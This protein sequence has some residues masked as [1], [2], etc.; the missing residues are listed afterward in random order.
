MN[1]RFFRSWRPLF[2]ILCTALFGT[3]HAWAVNHNPTQNEQAYP[4]T[5]SLSGGSV[6]PDGSGGFTATVNVDV[7]GDSQSLNIQSLTLK[8]TSGSMKEKTL[9][10]SSAGQATINV[11]PEDGRDCN[12]SFNFKLT[13]LTS[14]EEPTEGPVDATSSGGNSP[15]DSSSA[16]TPGTGGSGGADGGGGVRFSV[17]PGTA[18]ET[19]KGSAGKLIMDFKTPS[20]K[21]YL[22]EGMSATIS[23]QVQHAEYSST[24]AVRQILSNDKLTDVIPFSSGDGYEVREYP[25]SGVGAQDPSGLYGT[26][27]SPTRVTTVSNPGGVEIV[28]TTDDDVYRKQRWGNNFKYDFTVSNGYYRVDLD[29]A[30]LHATAAG[31]SVFNVSAQ[32]AV[33]LASYDAFSASGGKFHA[34]RETVY[35][36]VENGKLRLDFNQITGGAHVAAIKV[37]SDAPSSIAN[38]SDTALYQSAREGDTVAELA[39]ANGNYSV[40]LYFAETTFAAAGRRTF[41]V[42]LNGSVVLSDYDIY[43]EAGAANRAFTETFPVTVASGQL[44]IATTSI[45]DKAR[46]C[47]LLVRDT[48]TNLVV[49]AINAGGAAF[50]DSQSVVFSADTSFTGGTSVAPGALIKAVKAGAG[51]ATVA[52]VAYEADQA[53]QGGVVFAGGY[54]QLSI[55]VADQGMA[56]KTYGYQFTADPESGKFDGVV[57][58][59]P[60]GEKKEARQTVWSSDRLSYEDVVTLYNAND[61]VAFKQSVR[62][63]KLRCGWRKV[64]DVLDP[65]GA[66][67]ATTWTYEEGSANPADPKPNGYGLVKS[68]VRPDGAWQQYFYDADSRV[69]RQVAGYLNSPFGVESQAR[70]EIITYS[71][72]NPIETHVTTVQG[73]EVARSYLAEFDR[74]GD[75]EIDRQQITATTPGAAWNDSGNFVTTTC[76]YKSDHP[77]ALLRGQIKWTKAADGVLTAYGYAQSGANFIETHDRG[78][79][80]T[81]ATAV[82]AGTRTIT[83]TNPERQKIAE[84]VVDIATGL[85]LSNWTA[86]TVDTLGRSTEIGYDDGT[87]RSIAYVGSSASCGSC[88]GSGNFLIESET[89]RNGVITTYAYDALNRRTDTTRLGVTEHLVYDAAGRVTERHRIGTDDSDITLSSTTYDLAGRMTV[90]EDALGNETTY[91][92]SYPSGGGM[93]TTT[94]NPATAAGSGTRVE[95]TYADGHAKEISGTA[96]SPMKYAYGTWSASGAAGEWTQ[97]I[98]VGESASETEWT[99]TYDDLAGRTTKMEYADSAVATM[100]YNTLGQLVKQTDPD[101][102]RTLFSYNT[103]GEHEVTAIDLDQDDIIDYTGTDRIT[104]SVRDVYSKSGTIVSRTTTQVWATDNSNTTTTVSVA[105]QDGYGNASWQTD[106]A[107]AVA[108]TTIVRTAAG[109]WTVTAIAPDGS[110]RVQTYSSGRLISSEALN[111]SLSTITSTTYAYDAHNRVETQTDART[112]DTDYTYTDRDEMLTAVANNGTETTTYAYDALGNQL[113]ITRPDSSVTTNEYHLRN[114]L[115]KKTSGSLTYPVEYTYDPQGR[116]KTL[117]TWQNATSSTGAAVTT[118]NYDTQRGWLTQ[119]LYA[120]STGPAYT[121]TDAGR[122]ETRTWVRTVSS[123]PLVTT[124]TYNTLG[125]LT[126]TD[127]SDTTPDVSLTYTRFGA[128]KTVTDATGTRTFTYTAALRPDQEQLDASYYGSRILTRLYDVGL[129][130]VSTPSSVPGRTAGFLL[131]VTADPDQ[132]YAVN[133][134]YDTAGR[135]STVTDPSS[136]YTYAYTTN[137]NLRHTLTGPVHVATTTYETYRNVI[138]IVE[139]KVGSTSISKYDYT[140]NNLG[141]RTQR[142]NTGTAFATTSTDV[143]AYNG[144][145]EVTGSTNATIPAYDRG[146][147]YDDIGNRVGS[148]LAGASTSYTANPLNQY[149]AIASATPT[150][151]ADGNQTYAPAGTSSSTSPLNYIWDAEN[152]LVLIEPVSPTTGDKKQLNVYDA[153]SRRVRKQIS[154]YASGTW[155][156]TTDEKFIYDDWNLVAKLLWNPLTSTFDLNS[157]YTWGADLSGSLQGA[158]GVGGLLSVKD[159]GS[160]YHYTYDANGNVSE[161]VNNSGGIA[162]HYEYDAFGNTIASSGTYATTNTYCFSTK[163]LDTVA[164]L[165]YYGLRYYNPSIGRWLNRDPIQEGGGLNLYIFI[166]NQCSNLID[167]LGLCCEFEKTAA[168]NA[169]AAAKA[170]A[171]LVKALES[172]NSDASKGLDKA[173]GKLNAANEAFRNKTILNTIS[174]FGKGPENSDIGDSMADAALAAG[175][176]TASTA[177]DLASAASTAKG[178]LSAEGALS[179]ASKLNNTTASALEKARTASNLAD[180]AALSASIAWATCEAR[181]CSA[182]AKGLN[183]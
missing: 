46:L 159:G 97:E 30:E 42:T 154:T 11:T 132:D 124:Y 78:A 15:G 24:G 71:S 131:G 36:T 27:G 87:I 6:V 7:E 116:M 61:T 150:Y 157:T 178:P 99:K 9:T 76:Y 8:L 183:Q 13:G 56:A 44:T 66:A 175:K 91:A 65:D 43:S 176:A 34:K 137:S 164:G 129:D 74:T 134:A 143:F 86:L 115:L 102:V 53:Y 145:G 22:P 180:A 121:Y 90:T 84:Q 16:G 171:D 136:T 139:N 89:D 161:V 133:Y 166:G 153:Q 141:Q 12:C 182:A 45:I 5:I 18:G 88:S 68:E 67:I 14:G 28:G 114:N 54:N 105:E 109:A 37:T 3:G 177:N 63:E 147:S 55:T 155:S 35:T 148:L 108:S 4:A 52:G 17:D 169:E 167:I 41:N 39:L 21:M 160:V 29:F 113:T 31:Q 181:C 51:A 69:I 70:V 73:Q 49:A 58:T 94:T 47:A 179:D 122:L 32:G 101:G 23:S 173:K 107:G 142:A 10:I 64:R 57:L 25:R 95:T 38:T 128:Q 162:A 163:P 19:G 111:S 130:L 62:Y 125:D 127:Y 168:Q 79:P 165:Y 110:R 149:T 152:R 119:K 20:D 120:D 82:I 50:T 98:K 81:G 144:K 83:T 170:A 104:K 117:T 33:K 106:T 1:P 96:V 172:M 40:T 80:N 123:S 85:T 126:S 48:S 140:V 103:K 146:Y 92:Y 77:T 60:G 151:D 158:G 75:H 59:H 156:L 135:L 174:A 26:T 93:I 100:A 72:S 2:W 138:D 112:G 118:W